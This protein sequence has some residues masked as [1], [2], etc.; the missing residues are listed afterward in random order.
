[1][2]LVDKINND[3]KEAMKSKDKDKLMAL[4]AIKSAL[5]LAQTEKGSSGE[6]TEEAEMRILQKQLKQRK[7][8]AQLYQNQRREDLYENEIREAAIIEVYLPQMLSE[9]ALTAALEEIITRTKAVSL[10]DLGKIMG[11][12][13]KELAGKADGKAISELAKKLLS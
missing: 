5:L 8:S 3:L 4:R 6:V 9:E 7:E 11:I 12:A 10:K 1:M 13:S 2:A